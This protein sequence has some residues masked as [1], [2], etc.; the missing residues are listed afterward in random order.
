MSLPKAEEEEK[1]NRLLIILSAMALSAVAS[2][3]VVNCG[4]ASAGSPG[5]YGEYCVGVNGEE[6]RGPVDHMANTSLVQVIG[7][8]HSLAIAEYDVDPFFNWTFT[9]SANG[10]YFVTFVM[11]YVAG[12]Y[13]HFISS[14]SGSGTPGKSSV[15][16]KNISVT[17]E[18][19]G[20]PIAQVLN[21]AN[22]TINPPFSGTIAQQNSIIPVLSL[23]AGTYGVRLAFEHAGSG[24]I[25]FNGRV[26]LLNMI[27]EP[28]SM[29]LVAGAL[30]AAAIAGFRRRA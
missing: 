30:L 27:P 20:G 25:T 14:A 21:L 4:P 16:A 17:S 15:T 18:L 9:A 13:T 23:A 22:T 1:M 28:A 19:D 26:E 6:G 7:E 29:G 8:N 5:S 11:P 12:P 3:I 10:A 24:T 2:P